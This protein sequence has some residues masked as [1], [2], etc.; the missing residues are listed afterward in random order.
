MLK[1]FHSVREI[2]KLTKEG[3]ITQGE[4]ILDTARRIRDYDGVCNSFI[5][6][7]PEFGAL[8]EEIEAKG[9]SSLPGFSGPLSAVPFAV[10]DLIF[11]RGLPTTGGSKAPI[12]EILAERNQGIAITRLIESGA[13]LAGKNN[14]HEYAFG[15]TNENDHF[16]PVRNPWDTTRVSGGSSGGSAAAVAA[17][18]AAFAIG[19]DTRGSIRIPSSCCGVTGLKP[20]YK[21]IPVSGVVPLSVSLDHI[22]PITRDVWDSELIFNIMRGELPFPAVPARDREKT[23]ENLCIG[24][25]DYYFTHVNRE[26]EK[27]V[28]AALDVFRDR[29]L[30]IREIKM[31]GLEEILEASDI[32]SRYEAYAFH[33]VN[34]AEF[35][36]G[37]GPSVFSRLSSGRELTL[38]DLEEARKIKEESVKEFERVFSDVDCLLAPTLP[39]TAVP[40]G[41]SELNIDGWKESIVHGFVRFNAPQNMAGVPCLTVPCGFD[42]RGLPIGMQLISGRSREDILF[43]LGKLYQ[44]ETGWHLQ[45]PCQLTIDD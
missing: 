33:S 29:G 44:S 16:G 21:K 28:R 5:C 20:T 27:A 25:T 6:L 13:V 11:T 35:P 26:V 4:V 37:Y 31:S 15:I 12:P 23:A 32:V 38:A 18:M 2:I 10:K 22:G 43:A 7:N 19:T 30:E 14:L 3:R 24:I 41:T 17:G 9:E 1:S 40:L 36:A 42:S 45:R 8:A 39:V 34:L